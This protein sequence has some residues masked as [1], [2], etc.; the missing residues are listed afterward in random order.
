MVRMTMPQRCQ[1]C[2][3]TSCCVTWQPPLPV[4]NYVPVDE[5]AWYWDI[6]VNPRRYLPYYS[7]RKYV[8]ATRARARVM[9]TRE[10]DD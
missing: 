6:L 4:E 5:D 10:G 1:M 9:R 2:S 7:D 8:S 3:S